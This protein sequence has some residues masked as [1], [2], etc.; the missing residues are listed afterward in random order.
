MYTVHWQ[1]LVKTTETD[2]GMMKT[3]TTDE[4][5]TSN[6]SKYAAETIAVSITKIYVLGIISQ[7]SLIRQEFYF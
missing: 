2:S 6:Q 4:H 7:K 3:P 5:S 1:V